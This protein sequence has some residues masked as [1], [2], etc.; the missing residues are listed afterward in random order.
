MRRR[1]SQAFGAAALAVA[2]GTCAGCGGAMG[3]AKA[4]VD[5]ER[6][7]AQA[8]DFSLVPVGGATAVGPATFTGKVLIVDF[9]ATWCAPCRQ[10]FPEYQKLVEKF[11]GKLAVI[12][13]S[14][15]DAA[16]GIGKFKRETGVKFPLVWDQGQVVAGSY[17]P[18]TMPTSFVIDRSGI[19]HSIHE[20]FRQGDE[21]NLEQEIR[22]LL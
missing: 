4:P 9:W 15:D 6:V 1:F 10:S 7:G 19:V 13:V 16:D 11:D 20:G 21:A 22:S 8:P 12:G 5:S 2:L 18:G 14:V 17:K 3:D